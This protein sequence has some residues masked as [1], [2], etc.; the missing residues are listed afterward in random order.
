MTIHIC[1]VVWNMLHVNK[2]YNKK[3]FSDSLCRTR[4]SCHLKSV[5]KSA[6]I[7]IEFKNATTTNLKLSSLISLN[8]IFGLVSCIRIL[9][10]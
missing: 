1:V 4:C 9:Y 5:N 6:E 8:G 7:V 3:R 2:P 10:P